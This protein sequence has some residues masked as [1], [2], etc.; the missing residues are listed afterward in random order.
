VY[1]RSNSTSGTGVYGVSTSTSGFGVFGQAPTTGYA[2]YFVGRVYV[3]G[4]LSKA[5]GS[6]KI[7]HPL[8]PENKYLYHSFVESPDMMNIYNGNVVLN[9]TG[10]ATIL[11]PDWFEA[12]NKDFR[13]QITCIG[14]FAN[15]YIAEKVNKNKF[16]IA[17]GVDGL[18]ISWQVTGIRKDAYAEKNRIPIEEDKKGNVKGKYMHPEAFGLSKDRGIDVLHSQPEVTKATEPEVYEGL[19]FAPPAPPDI[20]PNR[21]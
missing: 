15:I 3:E 2:G 11:L 6:F 18:E 8:D 13:Y 12:L 5:A 20:E 1:G 14:G 7:D 19:H 16:K 10:E 4:T 9:E 21:E 17:G